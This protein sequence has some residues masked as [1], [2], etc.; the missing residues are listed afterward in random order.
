M[1]WRGNAGVL[2]RHRCRRLEERL[3][4]ILASVESAQPLLAAA[5]NF[6]AR[7]L[8]EGAKMAADAV[9]EPPG[10]AEPLASSLVAVSSILWAPQR[11]PEQLL[12]RQ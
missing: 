2:P 6:L 9:L 5:Q 8:P 3:G 10:P 4:V 12:T 7:V 11:K 1:G